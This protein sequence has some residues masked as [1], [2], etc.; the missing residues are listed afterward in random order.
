M[1]FSDY[2]ARSHRGEIRWEL[3]LHRE[4]KDVLITPHDDTLC[5]V[6]SGDPDPIEW[7]ATLN[8]AG[9]PTPQFECLASAKRCR[10]TPERPGTDPRQ[11]D[12]RLWR[13]ATERR[14]PDRLGCACLPRAGS[15]SP[16]K[17]KA[18]TPLG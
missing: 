3:F 9:F 4:V 11:A 8:Q 13:A 7:A 5:V 18:S 16:T 2:D 1:S 6:Y 15:Q 12:A 17:A 14:A 10:T